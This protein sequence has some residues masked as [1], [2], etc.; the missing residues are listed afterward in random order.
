MAGLAGQ[1]GACHLVD[2]LQQAVFEQQRPFFTLE[3]R[4]CRHAEVAAGLGRQD[5]RHTGLQVRRGLALPMALHK[6]ALGQRP[7]P[8][9]A[10]SQQQPRLGRA[11]PPP[12][13][14]HERPHGRAKVQ[15]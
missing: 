6:A 13:K 3:P 8:D 14:L 4:R 1:A 11:A 7:V 12:F 10:R 2:C 9:N 15:T 5:Q